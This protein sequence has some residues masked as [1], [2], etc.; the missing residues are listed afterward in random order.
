MD[1]PTPILVVS[2]ESKNR[3]ALADILNQEGWSTVCASA[4]A[5][6]QGILSSHN[7]RLVLCDRRLT[8][9]TYRDILFLARL[10]G[11]NV[12]VVVTSRLADWSEYLEA[13]QDGAFDL[14]AFPGET[15]EIIRVISQAR[16]EDQKPSAP[17]AVGKPQT[18]SAGGP[19]L[20]GDDFLGMGKPRDTLQLEPDV[21]QFSHSAT[22]D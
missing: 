22:E 17:F 16:R 20:T 9:G 11:R 1:K 7:L 10:L 3:R 4:V 14:I 18:V 5:E 12:R 15:A 19:L 8:D 21:T 13:L 2:S 6:C